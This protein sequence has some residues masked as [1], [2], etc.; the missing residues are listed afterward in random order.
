M[1]RDGAA[2]WLTV[3]GTMRLAT[4]W[5][6]ARKDGVVLRFTDHCAPIEVDGETYEP[7]ALASASARQR[8]EGL[9][10]QNAEVRG[11]LD[12][13]QVS[14]AD[15]A[16]G[17]YDGAELI[18]RVVDW[19]YPWAGTVAMNAYEIEQVTRDGAAWSA[20][21]VGLKG[22]LA[23]RRGLTL[24]KTCRYAFGDDDCGVTPPSLTGTVVSVLEGGRVLET[25]LTSSDDHFKDGEIEFT[26]GDADG[27]SSRI[28]SS[29][30]D[31]GRLEL[32][33]RPRVAP[34][35]GDSFVV[36]R[37]CDGRFESCVAYGNVLRFG[38]YPTIPGTDKLTTS[39]NPRP[40]T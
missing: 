17:A 37:G 12:G 3:G 18:E 39:P 7:G 32:H 31:G 5:R 25:S 4:C 33:A 19:R 38:G 28:K 23:Q 30:L 40:L 27:V 11:A 34:A 10:A 8:L 1:H 9:D 6:L 2:A 22:R 15:L 29:T 26:S 14:E 21:I 24:T 36:R 20:Q 35:P 16:G 13:D